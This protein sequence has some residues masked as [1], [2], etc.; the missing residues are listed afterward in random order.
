VNI[1]SATQTTQTTQTRAATVPEW[2]VAETRPS[3]SWDRKRLYYGADG[4]V[5]LSHKRE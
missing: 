5:C 4:Q 3:F 1:R 2:S